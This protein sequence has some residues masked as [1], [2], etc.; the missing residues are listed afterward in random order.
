MNGD[1]VIDINSISFIFKKYVWSLMQG[2]FVSNRVSCFLALK[3]N[4][5]FLVLYSWNQNF[6]LDFSLNVIWNFIVNS[7]NSN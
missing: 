3:T 1:I 2:F 7:L 5:Q 6:A 4:K